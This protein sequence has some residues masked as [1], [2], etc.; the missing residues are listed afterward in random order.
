MLEEPRT[1]LVPETLTS[2]EEDVELQA[3]LAALSGAW[4]R[5]CC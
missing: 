1:S 4:C 3:T 5:C 2:M